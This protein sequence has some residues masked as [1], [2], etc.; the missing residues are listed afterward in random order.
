MLSKCGARFTMLPECFR[1]V[2]ELISEKDC[3][4]TD[5]VASYILKTTSCLSGTGFIFMFQVDV[6]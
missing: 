3:K 2:Q 4:K 6:L 5:N 1:D